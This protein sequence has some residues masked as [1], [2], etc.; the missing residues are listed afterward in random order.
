MSCWARR[1][2]Q[3]HQPTNK[4]SV[5]VIF[6]NDLFLNFDAMTTKVCRSRWSLA[7]AQNS[8][9]GSAKLSIIAQIRVFPQTLFGLAL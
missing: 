2:I 3:K 8:L 7:D 1:L 9:F 5:K 4:F 6:K